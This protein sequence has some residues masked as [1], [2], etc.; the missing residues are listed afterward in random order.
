MLAVCALDAQLEAVSSRPPSSGGHAPRPQT[1]DRHLSSS[2][3][4]LQSSMLELAALSRT[5]LPEM[6]D[7]QTR[8]FSH[9]TTLGA[10]HAY[11]NRRANPLYSA[12]ALVG[13]LEDG[14]GHGGAPYRLVGRTL[15][16]LY[17]VHAAGPQP[18]LGGCLMWAAAIAGDRRAAEVLTRTTGT[19]SVR[20]RSSMEL[21]LV[22][23]GL[24]KCH[25][26][27]AR[28]R[29]KA[30]PAIADSRDELLRR[31][32]TSG[33]LFPDSGRRAD[34]R[35][36]KLASFASQVY[37]LH[38]LAELA[39]SMEGSVRPQCM[40]AAQ[41]LVE[42]QG[43][44]GQW[45][46]QYSTRSGHTVE[47]YPVYSVHQDGMAFMAL[48]ILH[49]LVSADYRGSLSRGLRWL[50]GANELG[51]SL[52]T[53]EPAMIFRCIQRRGADADGNSGM[54]R[55]NRA[56]AVLASV[57]LYPAPASRA[58]PGSLEILR[59]CRSYH[60]GWLLYAN[61]I[62]Q[63]WSSDTLTVSGGNPD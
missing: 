23:C 52:V 63:S 6:W 51:E 20:R 13:L 54:S 11:L 50:F 41:Q 34:P 31:F 22:L 25:E 30:A 15:D 47:G 39:R 56:R 33:K 21:G 7:S 3:A 42:E 12:V 45:W 14:A 19:L 5:L 49:S 10:D 46:W 40:R 38:G 55:S 36:G 62:V 2:A 44:E 57:G 58:K 18:A 59:E 43:P 8:L 26:H 61:S 48:G 9:K 37:P 53:R 24:L 28:L 17:P 60:L 1:G 16:A 29:S 4:A 32:S 27:N 35:E